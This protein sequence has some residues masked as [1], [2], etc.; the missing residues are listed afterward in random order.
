MK[1]AMKMAYI[2]Q[3]KKKELVTNVKAML[4]EKYPEVKV[5]CTF[6]VKDNQA[7]YMTIQGCSIDL[8]KNT[9]YKVGVD[10]VYSHNSNVF[11]GRGKELLQDC[12][13]TLNVDNEYD[14]D[15]LNGFPELR[16]YTHVVVGSEKSPFKVMGA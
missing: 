6:A 5:K 8:L 14:N 7:I 4:A 9:I 16:W 11:Y 10:A 13:N 12:V 15:G 2:S 1:G 3:S